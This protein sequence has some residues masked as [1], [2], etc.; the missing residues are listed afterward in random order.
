MTSLIKWIG[1]IVAAVLVA[2]L[3]P[4]AVRFINPPPLPTPSL[5]TAACSQQ[6]IDR[7]SI[8]ATFDKGYP[9]R[10]PG[11]NHIDSDQTCDYCRVVGDGANALSCT[12]AAP[13]GSLTG[14][15]L[16]RILDGGGPY[17][18]ECG[19]SDVDG[20]PAFWRIV[21]DHHELKAVDVVRPTGIEQARFQPVVESSVSKRQ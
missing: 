3:T 14:K 11:W 16:T 4:M 10:C 17:P 7:A 9:D 5:K 8:P 13:D 12:L 21:G 20:A 2:V 6:E 1:G 18:H 15:T 19:W